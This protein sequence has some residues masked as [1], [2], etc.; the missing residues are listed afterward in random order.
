V[1]EII[2]I[3]LLQGITL[4]SRHC[5]PPEA[6]T[7]A[8]TVLAEHEPLRRD[9]EKRREWRGGRGEESKHLQHTFEDIA[10]AEH[11]A[12]VTC[13]TPDLLL[14]HPDAALTTYV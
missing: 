2:I 5:S 13:T 1:I 3:L 9:G 14:K 8:G 4:A 10:T 11:D 12:I 6:T 7:F